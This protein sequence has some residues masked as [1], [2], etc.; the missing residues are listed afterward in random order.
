MTSDKSILDLNSLNDLLLLAKGNIP[1]GTNNIK[2]SDEFSKVTIRVEGE[3]Y[4]AFIPGEQLRSLWELQ[5]DFFRLAAFALHGTTDIRT[6]TP[7]E[8]KSFEIRVKTKEGSWLGEVITSDFWSSFF[9]N[10]VGKMTGFELGLTIT[11]CALICAGT[12]GWNS[13][14]KRLEAIK[15]EETEKGKYETIKEVVEL[16]TQSNSKF[17][18]SCVEQTDSTLNS[19]AERIAKRSHNAD[20]IVVASKSFDKQKIEQLKVRAKAE[21]TESDTILSRYRILALDKS[22]ELSWSMKVKDEITEE[23]FLAK[24]A[25]DAIDGDGEEAKRIANE[26]FFQNSLVELEVAVGKKRNLINSIE[27]VQMPSENDFDTE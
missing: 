2:L 24:L 18:I 27:P 26:A 1:E 7:D 21:P 12:I 5:N 15:R 4:G 10:T 6:L 16:F 23:E 25:P 8:R 19:V 17:G 20:H 9:A 14:N 22:S 3:G 11:V 13:Y